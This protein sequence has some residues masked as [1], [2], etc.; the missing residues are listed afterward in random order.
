MLRKRELFRAKFLF[1][2]IF[3]V[4]IYSGF[5]F[6]N[7]KS[8]SKISIIQN[9]KDKKRNVF[10]TDEEL[11]ELSS[12]CDYPTNHPLVNEY[13]QNFTFPSYQTCYTELERIMSIK[14]SFPCKHILFHIFVGEKGRRVGRRYVFSVS[15]TLKDLQ[16]PSN[17]IWQHKISI[18]QH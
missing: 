7:D 13:I 1:I 11:I 8:N 18:I 3:V 16:L 17:R 2:C 14:T 4:I 9:S 12:Q 6:S 10:I 15:F 5:V